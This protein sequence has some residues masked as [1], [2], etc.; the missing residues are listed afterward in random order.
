DAA[1][2]VPLQGPVR[3]SVVAVYPRPV[4][5]PQRVPVE[6]WTPARRVLAP[7]SRSDLDNV[8]KLVMDAA[9]KAG[10]WEDDRHV[11][12]IHAARFYAAPSEGP[13]VEV[14]AVRLWSDDG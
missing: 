9:S 7:T 2:E 1:P 3:V 13:R 4:S 14:E 6:Y 12:V 8:V 11:A 10:W 5:R